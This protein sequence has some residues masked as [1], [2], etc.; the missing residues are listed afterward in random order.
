[1]AKLST[2]PTRAPASPARQTTLS[3]SIAQLTA[4][5]A[6]DQGARELAGLSRRRALADPRHETGAYCI[7]AGPEVSTTEGAASSEYAL[8]SAN[9]KTVS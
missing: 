8:W 7:Q 2:S 9:T 5:T 4:Q 3:P 6:H 1:M